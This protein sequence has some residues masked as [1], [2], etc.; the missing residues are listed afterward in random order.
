MLDAIKSVTNEEY[1]MA[2]IYRHELQWGG[3]KNVCEMLQQDALI[4]LT[5][6]FK[7][8]RFDDISISFDR[9][10]DNK[11]ALSQV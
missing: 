4:Y 6:V 11:K 1:V 3:S 10:N 7:A 2:R 5:S 9:H 8:R